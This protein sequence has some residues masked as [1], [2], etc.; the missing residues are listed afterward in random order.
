M[1]KGVF[2]GIRAWKIEVEAFV[3]RSGVI[4]TED[5]PNA[6]PSMSSRS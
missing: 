2:I 5:K 4:P 1:R 6:Y 3:S